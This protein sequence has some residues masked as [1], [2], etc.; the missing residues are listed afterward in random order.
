V[1]KHEYPIQRP[2]YNA[3]KLKIKVTPQQ[4]IKTHK[5]ICM[6]YLFFIFGAIWAG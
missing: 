1:R 2:P 3:V 6:V 5:I 4:A